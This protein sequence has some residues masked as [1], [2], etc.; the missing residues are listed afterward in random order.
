GNSIRYANPVFV[1]MLGYERADVVGRPLSDFSLED[2]DAIQ[3]ATASLRAGTA[4]TVNLERTF[5]HRD[6]HTVWAAVSLHIPQIPSELRGLTPSD[7]PL[8]R[9]V[10]IA[11]DI[12]SQ[13]V[14]EARLR[15]N[16]Q[17]LEE[18]QRLGK[19]GHW[20]WN[21]IGGDLTWSDELYRIAG[22]DLGTPD[23]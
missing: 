18:A 13:K 14:A 6:G 11:Q 7:E 17:L 21:V 20:T 9:F 22:I 15:E 10:W 19:T 8:T 1:Q 5:K 2:E 12:T 4:K 3:T 23:L 16:Q